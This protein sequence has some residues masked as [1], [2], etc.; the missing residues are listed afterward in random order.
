MSSSC[1]PAIPVTRRLEMIAP[2][3]PGAAHNARR[4]ASGK[5]TSIRRA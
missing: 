4:S 2:G 5:K 3:T 1:S